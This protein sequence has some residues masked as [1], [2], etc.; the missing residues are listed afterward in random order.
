M[1][2]SDDAAY[3]ELALDLLAARTRQDR[4]A[5]TRHHLDSYDELIG[6]GIFDMLQNL[7]RIALKKKM[8]DGRP[9]DIDVF[10]GRGKDA[11]QI[12]PPAVLPSAARL[13]DLT[14][15]IGLSTDVEVDMKIDGQLH[16]FRFPDQSIELGR[17]PLMLHSRYCALHGLTDV[18]LRSKGECAFDR[19]GYFVVDGREKV[20]VAREDT[21]VNRLY[22]RPEPAISPASHLA[23]ILSKAPNSVFPRTATFYVNRR[24]GT[25]S[26]VVTKLGTVKSAEALGGK[27]A[28]RDE[29]GSSAGAS[30]DVPL[31]VLFRALGIESDRAILDHVSSSPD[32]IEF[33]RPSIVEAA[34]IARN[35]AEAIRFL[36]RFVPANNTLKNILTNDFLPSAGVEF[37]A[38]AIFLGRIVQ[39]LVATVIGTRAQ[40]DRDDYANKR[41]AVSGALLGELVRDILVRVRDAILRRLDVEWASGAWR[42]TGDPMRFVNA[43][44]YK[45]IFETR[46]LTERIRRSLKGDW[47]ADDTDDDHPSEDTGSFVQDLSRISYMAYLAHVRRVSNKMPEGVKLADPHKLRA[48]HWGAVCPADTPDGPNVG[49]VCHLATTAGITL[50]DKASEAHAR[51]I[52]LTHA[53]SVPVKDAAG[54]G[55]T[56]VVLNDIWIAVSGDPKGLYDALRDERRSGRLGRTTSISWKISEDEICVLTDRGRVVRPLVRLEKSDPSSDGSV[57]L[58]AP[59]PLSKMLKTK[60]ATAAA[61]APSWEDL[62]SA[63]AI[64]MLDIEE[65]RANALIATKAADVRVHGFDRRYTHCELHPAAAVLSVPSSTVPLMEYTGAARNTL[66]MA[67]IKQAISVYA[68]SYASRMDTVGYVLHQPQVPAVTTRFAQDLWG[69]NHGHGQNLCVAVCTYMGFNIDDALILNR[70]SV[71]RGLLRISVYETVRYEEVYDP[72]GESTYVFGELPR[73]GTY[74]APGDVLLDRKQ[75]VDG[76]EPRDAPVR[77]TRKISGVVDR[78]HVY[79]SVVDPSVRAVKIRLRHDRPPELGDKLATRF[80]QKGVVGLI[81]PAEDM[82][83]VESTGMVPDIIFNPHSIPTRNTPSHIIEMFLGKAAALAGVRQYD[84]TTFSSSVRGVDAVSEAKQVLRHRGL[85]ASGDETM[86]NGLTGERIDGAIFTGI[87]Y[88]GRLKHMVADKWQVRVAQGPVSALTRQPTKTPGGGSGGLRIGEMERDALYSHGMTAFVKESFMER[89]DG[90][91]GPMSRLRAV[92]PEESGATIDGGPPREATVSVPHAFKL[93]ADELA[94]M[95]IGAL[96]ETEAAADPR[97]GDEDGDGNGDSG[98]EDE[99]EDEGSLDADDGD[100]DDADAGDEEADFGD[101]DGDGPGGMFEEDI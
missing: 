93:F 84:C 101:G 70:A 57:P 40:L 19:G 100:L 54:L 9:V 34:K 48:S 21:V 90:K 99:D 23:W 6:K 47:N 81:L 87:N 17:V 10:F 94:A 26:V 37:G 82:P 92:V 55:A 74:V 35:Q 7:D 24:S 39:Q 58:P 42:A 85:D 88:Y 32:V 78:V 49:L 18:E 97:D 95:S 66:A 56:R 52:V 98:D 1:A 79:P 14:Y 44:N 22:V 30:A 41:I 16:T 50:A 31:F 11:L 46:F 33:L 63:G 8:D 20:I 4:Y 53:R 60:A 59:F 15:D 77:A 76:K 80:S 62:L 28:K 25:I 65:I 36:D 2:A 86:I 71:E 73:P 13:N 83:Y 67:Q 68:T 72:S 29:P 75:L 38:K 89:S 51:E 64:E 43:R 61:P 91:P 27:S 3:Q 96:L 12:T 45:Q 5:L 69:G